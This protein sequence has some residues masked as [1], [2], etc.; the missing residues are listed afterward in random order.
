MNTNRF[1][2]VIFDCDG[3]LVDSEPIVNRIFAEVL[4]EAG[5]KITYEEVMQQFVGKSLATCLE[6]IKE[7][8][9]RPLPKNFI[10]LCRERE[11]AALQKELQPV[12]GMPEVLKQ[13]TLLKCVASNSSHRHIQMVLTLTELLHHFQGKLYSCHDVERPKPFPDVYL[14]AAQQMNTNPE[15]CLVI[16]DSAT[17]VQAACAA[18]MTVFGYAQYNDGAEEAF[19]GAK[20][21]FNNMQQLPKML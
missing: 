3:V 1:E 21:V 8:Y 19:N 11:I 6:M 15:N 5:F 7:F 10:E 18:G 16:E 13:I 4:N 9:G 2:L 14:Y 12:P 17:G 20:I